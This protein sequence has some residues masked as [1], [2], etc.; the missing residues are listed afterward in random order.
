MGVLKGEGWWAMS[1][2]NVVDFGGGNTVGWMD[3]NKYGSME[4]ELQGLG[5]I[6]A[7]LG[8]EA[9]SD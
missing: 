8:V 2:D 3:R 1:Y 7:A 9:N 6:M 5:K 4:G